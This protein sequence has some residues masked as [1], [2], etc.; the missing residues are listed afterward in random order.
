MGIIAYIC[1]LGGLFLLYLIAKKKEKVKKV[2]IYLT[3]M[4]VLFYILWRLIY[5][6]NFETGFVGFFSLVLFLSEVVSAF[7]FIV[8]I[9]LFLST[10]KAESSV[11]EISDKATVDI[12]ICTY[13]EDI[14]LVIATAIAAKTIAYANKKIYICDDG[15]REELKQ[16]AA[17]YDVQYLSRENN[18]NAK[19][20]NINNALRQTTGEF[21]LV[22]DADFIPKEDIILRAMVNF[23][24]E[25][26]G[27]VQFP[28]T[29]YNKD[30]F[31]LLQ[32]NMHN[33]Q[34]LFMRFIEPRLS[35]YNAMIHIGTNAVIRRT[36]IEAIGGIP[37]KS[38]TE[39]MA[40][41][42]FLQAGG[43]ITKYV[44]EIMALG[45]AP[46]RL[47]DLKSQRQ[48]W[49]RGTLQ[50]FRFY[51]PL[52]LKKLSLIQK[53]LYLN[54][55]LYWFTSFQ[56]LVYIIAPTLFMM[57]GLFIVKMDMRSFFYFVVPT[58][59]VISLSFN[60]LIGKPRNFNESHIYD[61]LMAPIHAGAIIKEL[62]KSEKKFIVT[63]KSFSQSKQNDFAV[64][65]PHLL[66]LCWCLSAL[67]IAVINW[68]LNSGYIPG[69]IICSLWTIYN[70]YG[71]L[72]AI[73]VAFRH[74]VDSVAEA[75]SISIDMEVLVDDVLLRATRMSYAGF[76]ISKTRNHQFQLGYS[77]RFEV[78]LTGLIINA[79]CINIG[80]KSVAFYFD[81]TDVDTAMRIMYFYA[82]NLHA[83]KEI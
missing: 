13:N 22:L 59:I 17:R 54:L 56:K 47:A 49:A 64:I 2:Y 45:M 15:N 23:N 48:R 9:F 73:S 36:A 83:A 40:T 69:I 18:D 75:L 43:Y 55:Y 53:I 25:Q 7:V 5:T 16:K 38:I 57:F 39:D 35:V 68:E 70:I 66:L 72:F 41:G 60:L 12:F 19:A 81:K 31:Q 1:L 27:M 50:T 14:S 61:T 52:K 80:E 74:K 33:E 78:I 26:V 21:F 77:Y 32:N 82:N 37:L 34:D 71:L 58:L 79:K 3:V 62:V 44:N 67:V 42:L 65:I 6:L 29:F 46:Y 24:D 51:N 63:Q 11:G 20:G 30:P 4:I 10:E 76:S 8:F 28:Q